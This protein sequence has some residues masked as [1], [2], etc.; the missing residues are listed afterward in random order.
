MTFK[1]WLIM[2]LTIFLAV[3]FISDVYLLS[4]W[5]NNQPYYSGCADT[6]FISDLPTKEQTDNFCIS[7]GYEWGAADTL[8]CDNKIKCFKHGIDNGLI[9]SCIE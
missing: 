4:I 5:V 3:I 2:I 1:E 8:I 9:V 7:R 6:T